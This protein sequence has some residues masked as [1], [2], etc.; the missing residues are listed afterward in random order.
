VGGT[1]VG[2][3]ERSVGVGTDVAVGEMGVCVAVGC[4]GV[5]VGG[6]GVSVGGMGV[7][8]G[9]A[10]TQPVAK[11]RTSIIIAIALQRVCIPRSPFVC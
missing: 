2:L 6:T 1:G 10:A 9:S 5:A 3:G 4:T 11:V 8:A 7:A